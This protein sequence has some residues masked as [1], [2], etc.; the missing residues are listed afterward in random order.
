VGVV[1][2]WDLKSPDRP[3]TLR[4]GDL[5]ILAVAFAGGPD[6][7]RVLDADL[8]MATVSLDAPPIDS[9]EA[10]RSNEAAPRRDDRPMINPNGWIYPSILSFSADGARCAVLANWPDR[11]P[12]S[13]PSIDVRVISY[14]RE[15]AYP[16][17]VAL[18]PDG[19]RFVTARPDG[20]LSIRDFNREK[21]ERVMR[22]SEAAPG[23]FL[24]AAFP[25][26]SPHLLTVDHNSTVRLRDLDTGRIY[27]RGKN[28]AWGVRAASLSGSTLT[29]VSG[30]LPPS[31]PAPGNA[32]PLTVQRFDVGSIPAKR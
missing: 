26:G 19:R 29:V 10:K 28:P 17:V 15:A 5:P 4:R 20:A 18:A 9:R 11:G 6:R 14:T 30:G 27:F 12:T 21:S 25:S 23:F 8:A 24:F 31:I 16:R 32:T 13:E 7:V 22:D 3:R 1:S 2:L